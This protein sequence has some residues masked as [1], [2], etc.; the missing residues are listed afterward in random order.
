MSAERTTLMNL[1]YTGLWQKSNTHPT[2]KY[3]QNYSINIKLKNWQKI[4][5][6]KLYRLAKIFV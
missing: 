1:I 3:I 6:I 2:H 5:M 4:N